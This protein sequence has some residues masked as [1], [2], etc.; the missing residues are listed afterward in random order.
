MIEIS[1]LS[2][3][4][5]DVGTILEGID[6]KINQGDFIGIL[7]QNGAGKT[8]FLDLIMGFRQP[9]NGNILIWDEDPFL[10][11]RSIFK[12]ISYVSQGIAFKESVSVKDFFSFHK[13]F[14]KNYSVEEEK[15]LLEVFEI[16]RKLKIGALSTGGKRRVQIIAA[17]AVCPKLLLI[18]EITAVLD[19][20][21]RRIFFNLLQEFSRRHSTTILLATNIVE[22]LKGIVEKVFFI[23]NKTIKEFKAPEIESLFCQ[24]KV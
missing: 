7:G 1:Q 11:D 23:K 12:E 16:D 9:N 6:F 17:L 2:Y 10:S 19:P 3:S 13:F 14:F 15:R 24:E 22:D 21:A 20:N 18:D 8:T 4:I 5:P